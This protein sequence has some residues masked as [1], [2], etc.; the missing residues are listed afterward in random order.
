MDRYTEI[1]LRAQQLSGRDI[2]ASVLA[3][4]RA[5]RR[6]EISALS[7]GFGVFG[8]TQALV[9]DLQQSWMS[10]LDE[11]SRRYFMTFEAGFNRGGLSDRLS[12][13]SRIIPE[14]FAQQLS[15]FLDSFSAAMRR[16]SEQWAQDFAPGTFLGDVLIA[17]GG[18][19]SADE[20]LAAIDRLSENWFRSPL[21]PARFHHVRP[22]L[23]ARAADN[24]TTARQEMKMSVRQSLPLA[25]QEHLDGT[26]VPDLL[27]ACRA[28]LANYLMDDLA[29]P[30]W[31]QRERGVIYSLDHTHA[32]VERDLTSQYDMQL[33]ELQLSFW[34]AV[35]ELPEAQR[36]ALIARISGERP[37]R[38]AEHQAVFR[39]RASSSMRALLKD[40]S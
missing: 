36:D 30:G 26:P 18:E 22:E 11:V 38:N 2:Q 10:Q 29:G 33:K 27:R 17:A 40:V 21:H 25:L 23:R 5:S 19:N 28:S 15:P 31:R 8:V 1:V 6:L 35:A 3:A 9:H 20:Q 24:G 32:D 37:L 16:A 14:N 39:A 4:E 13:I 7:T 34:A 12:Q